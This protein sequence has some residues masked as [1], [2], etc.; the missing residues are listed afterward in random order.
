MRSEQHLQAQTLGRK[1][2]TTRDM[3]EYQHDSRGENCEQKNLEPRKNIDHAVDKQR[4]HRGENADI[5]HQNGGD[6]GRPTD[7]QTKRVHGFCG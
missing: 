7:F 2:H 6:L 3:A 5:K 4:R 1:F